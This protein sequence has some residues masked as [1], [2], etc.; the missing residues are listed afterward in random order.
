MAYLMSN[1]SAT[2]DNIINFFI[3]NN[4]DTNNYLRLLYRLIRQTTTIDSEQNFQLLDL[5]ELVVE[6][7]LNALNSTD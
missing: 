3:E 7:V 4:D 5:E 6:D 1:S 2:I